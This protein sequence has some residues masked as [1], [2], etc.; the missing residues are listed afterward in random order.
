MMEGAQ[1]L[2]D[3]SETNEPSWICH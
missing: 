2:G 1:A 3:S